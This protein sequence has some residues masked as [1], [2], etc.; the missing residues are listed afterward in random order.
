[1]HH[2]LGAPE[3]R[4]A[5]AFAGLH[6]R[7]ATIR[8][9]VSWLLLTGHEGEARRDALRGAAAMQLALARAARDDCLALCELLQL[10]LERRARR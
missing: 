9:G 6:E 2:M 3:P 5:I 4:L 7:G 8:H 1:M 10:E